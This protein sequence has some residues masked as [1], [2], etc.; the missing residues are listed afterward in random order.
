M[1]RA[2]AVVPDLMLGTREPGRNTWGEVSAPSPGP[3]LELC[4]TPGWDDRW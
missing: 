2:I 3:W 1:L 4:E